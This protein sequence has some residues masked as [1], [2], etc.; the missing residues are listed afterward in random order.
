MGEGTGATSGSLRSTGMRRTPGLLKGEGGGLRCQADAAAFVTPPFVAYP[1]GCRKC[2]ACDADAGTSG[3]GAVWF[4]AGRVYS[5]HYAGWPLRSVK[6]D[7]KCPAGAWVPLG[8]MHRVGRFLTAPCAVRYAL[9]WWGGERTR[10]STSAII[11]PLMILSLLW[12]E[13]AIPSGLCG[14]LGLYAS[15]VARCFW[16]VPIWPGASCGPGAPSRARC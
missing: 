1:G 14:S 11:I 15:T 12:M 7:G 5:P 16:D 8:Y 4:L 9:R 6:W 13:R 10:T 2:P 3:L